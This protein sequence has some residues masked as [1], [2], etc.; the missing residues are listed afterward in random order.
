MSTT[1][2]APEGSITRTPRNLAADSSN[3]DLPPD[4]FLYG[5]KGPWPQPS[6]AHPLKAAAEVLSVP[7]VESLIWDVTVGRR[8]VT[9]SAGYTGFAAQLTRQDLALPIPSDADFN[10][11]MWNTVYS[12]FMKNALPDN[13]PPPA[14]IADAIADLKKKLPGTVKWWKYD[15]S[16]MALVKPLDGFYCAPVVCIFAEDAK[17]NRSCAAIIFRGD[18][19]G[20]DA[21]PNPN[22]TVYPE[23]PA[24]QLAKIF[25]LQGAAYHM[26]FVVHP[27]L[28]FPMDSVNAITKTAV[29]H[30]H[31]LFQLLYPH[32]SYT[33]ALDNAV[34]EG[35]ESVVND[36]PMGTSFDP[37]MGKAYNLKLLFAAGYTGLQDPWYEGGAYP[38]YD[39]MK[40]QMGF[41]SDYG[42]WLKDYF[43]V[44]SFCFAR[45]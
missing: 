24:W 21:P 43:D 22:L 13:P 26:L 32:T 45:G 1:E 28:H 20:Q 7:L 16:A 17:K 3:P 4:M 33:L 39:Y 31:P 11:Y 6:P 23:D 8:L 9:N 27:A 29:P 19:P 42:M 38:A 40:P 37:L 14:Y 25:A 12:R 35:P 15:F 5:R 41:D 2:S 44:I 18:R 36:N 30:T 34:L 10:K